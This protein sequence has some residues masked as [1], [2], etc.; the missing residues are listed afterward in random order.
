MSRN[1]DVA[2]R[3]LRWR[4]RWSEADG[5]A[6]VEAWRDSGL[7]IAAF[8]RRHGFDEQRIER[9]R[10]RIN[11]CEPGVSLVPV[12]VVQRAATAL[13]VVVGTVVIRVAPGFDEPTLRRVLAVVGT[14]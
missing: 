7:S 8:A 6:A 11:E 1:T 5:R 4:R 2:M 3:Q 9:W 13:E 12:T 10:G 14:C